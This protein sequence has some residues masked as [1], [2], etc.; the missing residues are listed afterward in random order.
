MQIRRILEFS[1]AHMTRTP[2]H[3]KKA[4]K[5]A[6]GLPVFYE[7]K[8]LD[9]TSHIKQLQ[10]QRHD[11]KEEAETESAMK[12]RIAECRKTLEQNNVLEEFDCYIFESIVEKVIVGGMMKKAA[13][14]RPS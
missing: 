11:L 9:L 5:A 2:K 6:H 13:K 10:A 3:S 7:S 12:K 14:T 1:E 4:K 8:Y